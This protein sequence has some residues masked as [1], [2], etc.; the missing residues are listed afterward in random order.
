MSGGDVAGGLFGELAG[1]HHGEQTGKGAVGRP[2]FQSLPG[3][4]G[5][6]FHGGG[7]REES[8]ESKGSSTLQKGKCRILRVATVRS[9]SRAMAAIC[10][11]R[12]SQY[13]HQSCPCAASNSAAY[14]PH[15]AAEGPSKSSKR[16][17]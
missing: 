4:R 16:L 10:V 6:G 7:W 3:G 5:T 2:L 17:A 12:R 15:S 11:S 1:A 8:F 9:Y 14:R 13:F